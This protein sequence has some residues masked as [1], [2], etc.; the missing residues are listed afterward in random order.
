MRNILFRDDNSLVGSYWYKL[1]KKLF[2]IPFILSFVGLLAIYSLIGS[3]YSL[4]LLIKHFSYLIISISILIFITFLSVNDLRRILN[5]LSVLFI[6]LLFMVPLLGYEIKGA[7][8]WINLNFFSIQPSEILKGPLI[9]MFSWFF[10]LY[11]K[12][13]K[14]HYIFINLMLLTIVV[15]LLLLQPDIGTLF[16]YLSS[17]SLILILYLRKIR[18]IFLLGI[19][20]LIFLIVAYFSFEHVNL[21][22]D[23]FIFSENKNIQISKSLSAIKEG[24]LFGVGLG[25]GQ[26][27]YSIPESH[28]DFIFAILIEEF[29]ILFGSFIALLYPIF[30]IISKKTS[31]TCSNLFI[32]NTI[33]T[34]C[35]IL[36]LQAFVNIGSSIDLIPPTG[37]TLPFISYGGSS[38]LSYALI[39]GTVICFS[40]NEE[41]SYNY[42]S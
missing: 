21:R 7:T 25:E 26:L 19:L 38:M 12:T 36:C 37:M 15:I 9:C 31:N 20:G 14:K 35:F 29:G 41:S 8:R 11:T 40:K 28:N 5:L 3:E 17:F 33:F 32:Q 42:S 2:V 22:I 10:Y 34:L 16:I 27:K 4:I 39:F 18:H 1:P 6:L 23:N 24:G 13:N 30:F